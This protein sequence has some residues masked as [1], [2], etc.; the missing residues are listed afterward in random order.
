[1]AFADQFLVYFLTGMSI[2]V[3]I[4]GIKTGLIEASRFIFWT[5]GKL[6]MTFYLIFPDR[7]PPTSTT[8]LGRIIEQSKSTLMPFIS[9]DYYQKMRRKRILGMGYLFVFIFGVVLIYTFFWA[10][11]TADLNYVLENSPYLL[12]SIKQMIQNY[13]TLSRVFSVVFIIG[14]II[15]AINSI[16]SLF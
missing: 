16:R 10:L 9:R 3:T 1:M 14:F 8:T 12:G 6:K 13:Q 15:E 4:K 7:Q 5:F 11:L 2:I